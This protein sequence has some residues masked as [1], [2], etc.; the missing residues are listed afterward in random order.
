MH[1]N[2]DKRMI[3]WFNPR[4]VAPESRPPFEKILSQSLYLSLHLIKI[5]EVPLI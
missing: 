2:F 1:F 4:M 3:G 5:S